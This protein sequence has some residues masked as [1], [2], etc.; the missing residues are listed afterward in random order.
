MRTFLLICIWNVIC[1][2]TKMVFFSCLVPFFSFICHLTL[3]NIVYHLS[4]RAQLFEGRLTLNP[5]FLFHVFKS[6]F[7]DNFLYFF[8]ELPIINLKTKKN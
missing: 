7:S 2:G 1:E 6:I 5:G 3:V 4:N 8:L